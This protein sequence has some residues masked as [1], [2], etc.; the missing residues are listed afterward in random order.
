MLQADCMQVIVMTP[1]DGEG[2][3]QTSRRGLPAT[4]NGKVMH[5]QSLLGVCGDLLGVYGDLLGGCGGLMGGLLG[6]CGGLMGGLF[7][8]CDDLLGGCGGLL[9]GLRRFAAWTE[10][11]E[12]K[13]LQMMTKSPW[14]LRRVFYLVTYMWQ[15]SVYI[16]FMAVFAIFGSAIG[17]KMFTKN[18]WGVQVN[19]L[20]VRRQR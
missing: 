14:L 9:G 17:L 2:V 7:G 18:S 15:M 16:V 5:E 1:L 6:G 13:Q 20:H 12:V 19:T 3:Q 8:G 11:Q 4:G 10:P